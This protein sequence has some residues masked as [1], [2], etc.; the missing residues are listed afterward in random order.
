MTQQA[1]G[2]LVAAVVRLAIKDMCTHEPEHRHYISAKIFFKYNF[3]FICDYWPGF[4]QFFN[5]D[6][7]K[8][9]GKMKFIDQKKWL[10]IIDKEFPEFVSRARNQSD[11]KK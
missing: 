5:P 1:V 6:W 8:A 3:R 10:K 11:R 4:E 9:H 2:D 7:I